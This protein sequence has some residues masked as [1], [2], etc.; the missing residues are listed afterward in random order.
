MRKLF[1]FVFA[2][3]CACIFVQA[4]SI[5]VNPTG[6]NVNSQN[7]TVVFLTFGQIPAGYVP[8]EAVWCGQLIPAAPPSVGSICRPDTIYGSLP[9]RYDF[10]QTSG[11]LGLTDIM[12][13]P[14]SV[15]RRAYQTALNGGGAGFFYVRRFVSTSG[16]P[17]QYVNVTCRMTGGG[18]RVPFALT[19]VEFQTGSSEPVLFVGPNENFSKLTAEIQYNGTGRLKGRWELVR[20]GEEPPTDFDLMTEGSLPLEERDKQKRFL[21]VSRFNHFLPPSG[22]F[23]LPL[24]VV[25]HLPIEAEGQY[26]LLLR[27]E[28]VDDKES[29]SD[30]RV[31]GVGDRVVH[32]G[33]VAGFPM[34]VLK[35]FVSSKSSSINWEADSLLS[36]ANN[37]ALRNDQNIL[38]RWRVLPK[39]A[40]YRLEIT[41]DNAVKVLSAILVSPT[42]SYEAPS[43][44]RTRFAGQR[45]A[46]RISALDE[47]ASIIKVSTI[48]SILLE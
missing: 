3:L 30:L 22:K 13:I 1:A 35:F 6:V 2:L 29:D 11:N 41:D 18:A 10:S 19:N 28:S 43:W 31:I 16:Q 48:R 21:Q 37:L 17:D 27:I 40:F 38:F 25:N 47:S 34:P 8:A 9:R 20:P 36:P 33:A 32:S 44:L 5:K 4:Q 12:S 39:A 7:P 45:L 15:T 26:L 42:T 24:E 23:S 14:A 46:W